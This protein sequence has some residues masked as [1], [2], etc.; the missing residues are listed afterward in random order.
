MGA[1]PNDA[2]IE[3][4]G[5]A[6]WDVAKGPPSELKIR[7]PWMIGRARHGKLPV[8]PPIGRRNRQIV[9]ARKSASHETVGFELPVFVSVRTKPLSCVVLPLAS[10]A[11]RNSRPGPRPQFLDQ[12]VLK[13]LLH[14]RDKNSTIFDRP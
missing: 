6:M 1:E 4:I 2:P 8:H 14:F 11:N 9:N 10:E 5:A 13:F 7:K 3:V 12:P